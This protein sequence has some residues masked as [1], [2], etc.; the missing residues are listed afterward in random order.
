MTKVLGLFKNETN[1]ETVEGGQVLF[2][3]GAPGKCMYVLRAGRLGV[4]VDGATVE[5]VEPGGVVGEM[6]LIDDGPRSATVLA[7]ADSEVVPVDHRR[8][9]FLVQQTPFFA[10]E[11]MRLMADRLRV[12]N[13]RVHTP[14]GE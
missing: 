8:F 7:L 11:V 14:Q 5:T 12:M 6:S 3:A 2:E 1:V 13:T 4:V 10:V 9:L